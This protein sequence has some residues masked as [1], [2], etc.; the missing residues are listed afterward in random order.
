MWEYSNTEY[1]KLFRKMLNWEW[2]TDIN[3]KVLF[4]HCL[5][6]AN[7]KDGSWHGVPYK[8]GQFI[9]SLPTLADETGLTIKQVRTALSHLKRTGEVADKTY[10]KFRIITVLS[11]DSFQATGRQKGRQ[12]ATDIRSIRNIKN[13]KE[14][15][16]EV[17]EISDEQAR[18]W[19]WID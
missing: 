11:Y 5:L 7:W 8:R 18:E 1:I 3:T 12:G 17:Q 13:I 16:E 4:L 6:K 14:D 19:G 9:T 2:Y 10:S 15:K